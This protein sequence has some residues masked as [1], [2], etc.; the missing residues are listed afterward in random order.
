MGCVQT[1]PRPVGVRR[2]PPPPGH[3]APVLAF[4]C[5]LL[6]LCMTVYVFPVPVR[7]AMDKD[8]FVIYALF[9]L[10]RGL[11]QAM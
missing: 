5:L 7:L 6:C 4:A 3:V 9:M 1:V 8:F 10:P 2:P 11:G